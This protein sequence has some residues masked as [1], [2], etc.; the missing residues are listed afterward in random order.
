MYRTFRAIPA[1]KAVGFACAARFAGLSR[2]SWLRGSSALAGLFVL[3]AGSTAYAAPTGGVVAAGG[4]TISGSPSA[5]TISQ[6]TQNTAINWQGFSIGNGEAVNFV[7]PNSSAVALNRVLGP[8]PS[9][10]LGN[11]SANGKVFLV[12]PSGVLFGA[13]SQVNVGGLVAST[14]QISDTDFM[15]G[16]YRFSGAGTG[17]V[18]NQ[19]FITADGGSVA[20]LGANVSNQG[21]ISAR[22]G[23]VSLAAGNAMTLDVAGDGLLAVTVNEGAVNALAENGGLI[24][25]DG[26]R[27]LMTAS[28]VNALFRTAVN[29]SGIIEART[30]ESRNGTISLMGDMQ[31]GTVNV[32]GTLDASAPN[33]GDG[34]FIETSGQSVNIADQAKITT[35]APLGVTGNWL[36]DPQDFTVSA[37]GNISGATLSALLVTNSVTISTDTGTDNTVAGTPPVTSLH[38]ATPGNG[39]INVNDAVSW[40]ATP[41][42]TTLS[43]N[44]LRDVN[45]NAA[46]TATNGNVVVCCG[47]DANINAPITTTNGSMLLSAGRNVILNPLAT[48]VT[49]DGNI[50]ICAG[51]NVSVA[52]PITLTRGSSIPSQSLG[53]TQGLFIIAGYGGTG[54][55]TAGGTLIY[56][57]L[58]AKT[59]VTGPNAPVNIDYNPTSY[60]TPTDYTGDFTLTGGATV[61]LHMLVFPDG[62]KVFDGTTTTTLTGFNST[63]ASG[64]PTGVTLVAGPGSSATFDS[65]N[66]GTNI[67]ITYSGYTLGGPNASQYALAEACCTP[68]FRTTGTI[69]AAAVIAPPVTTPPVTPPVTT[70]PVTTPPGTT[71]PGTTPPGTT[72]PG[73]TPSGPTLGTISP[74]GSP[75]VRGA[76]FSAIPVGLFAVAGGFALALQEGGVSMPAIQVAAET[77]VQPVPVVAPQVEAAAYVPPIYTRKQDRN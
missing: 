60:A 57:P 18:V 62:S 52:S 43:L 13:N 27:V 49:T 66:V 41:S 40:T 36:I 12:N 77:P 8:D 61:T 70:P 20:L 65:P 46:I 75:S 31:S 59:T 32:S 6:S 69:T 16:Q 11:L 23:A 76:Q 4:A 30:L 51:L 17:S 48:L 74:S 63:I 47:R 5:M 42:T 72:P 64:L 55:G 10:I 24:R 53:L 9:T 1:E 37:T 50:T 25:A 38:T 67:G 19:G 35:A 26:G 56:V 21:V 3:A 39:D 29:N 14:L 71:P 34:G 68:T 58:T 15:A 45:V 44:A 73:T 2:K 22:M 54:P 7:Q 28:S 33:G